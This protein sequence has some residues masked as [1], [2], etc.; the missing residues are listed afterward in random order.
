[1]AY[2]KGVADTIS[3]TMRNSSG[4]P[5]VP[6]SPAAEINQDGAGFTAATNAVTSRG[7]G[8]VSLALTAAEMNADEII[9]RFTG[10]GVVEEQVH[11]RTE[12]T[13]TSTVAGRLDTNVGSRASQT[14]LDTLDDYVD[15][16]V[17]AIKAKTDGLNFTGSYVQAQVKGLDANTLTAAALAADA[18]TEI[19]SGLSTLTTAEVLTQIRTALGE[20]Y[21]DTVTADSIYE[22][23]KTLDD[24][25]TAAKAAN[26]DAAISTRLAASGYTAPDNVSIAAILVD[27]GELQTDWTN[28]GG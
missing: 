1:M 26:L 15:T 27:T 11:I 12:A 20:D 22:R 25:Y 9:V 23:L 2:V 6:T 24:A 18:V 21:G 10:T 8:A 4:V 3:T 13:W 17:A 19:Q 7:Y 16:E 28:G 5:A 14:S